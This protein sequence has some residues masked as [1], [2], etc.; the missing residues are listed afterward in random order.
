[1][2]LANIPIPNVVKNYNYEELLDENISAMKNL[3]PDWKPSEG[4]LSLIILE[5]LSYREM[6]L[7]A[8]FNQLSKAFFLPTTT[9]TNLDNYAVFYGLERLQGSYPI[10][11]YRFE[12][13]APLSYSVVIPKGSTFTDDGGQKIAILLEDVLFDAGEEYKD[14]LLEL[15]EYVESSETETKIQQ[16]P[17]PYISKVYSLEIFQNGKS[18]E[19]DDRFR[20]RILFSFADKSTAGSEE[21]YKSYV[22]KADSRIEDVSVYSPVAGTVVVTIYAPSDTEKIALGRVEEGLNRENIRPLTDRVIVQ[23]AKIVNYT[24][25]A[26][27]FIYPNQDSAKVYISALERLDAGLAKLEKINADITISELNL[28]LMADGVKEVVFKS[29]TKRLTIDIESI[30]ICNRKKINYEVY[31]E[32]I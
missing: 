9:D 23:Y 31:Y 19:S 4:D 25:E 30:A 2:N 22:Y 5:A 14:G 7:R 26:T 12:L 29:P 24:I 8:Y 11:R 21:S 16:T 18:V 3:I 6:Y 32:Q 17:L 10:A 27:L 20:E 1:M 15:Q 13:T 28:F